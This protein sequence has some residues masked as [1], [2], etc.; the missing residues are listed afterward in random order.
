MYYILFEQ[1]DSA[2]ELVEITPKML[3]SNTYFQEVYFLTTAPKFLTP[4]NLWEYQ[5]SLDEYKM[6]QIT[7]KPQET[8]QVNTGTENQVKEERVSTEQATDT[9]A[10]NT[11]SENTQ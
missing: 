3:S 2:A 1:Q 7:K 6:L 8:E 5:I 10:Q 11:S 9:Q 4:H